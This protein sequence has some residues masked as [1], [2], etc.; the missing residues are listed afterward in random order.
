MR[1]SKTLNEIRNGEKFIEKQ[2]FIH[3]RAREKKGWE[4]R[5]LQ[6]TDQLCVTARLH[7]RLAPWQRERDKK[8]GRWMSAGLESRVRLEEKSRREGGAWERRRGRKK[9]RKEERGRATSGDKT[10]R[11][12]STTVSAELITSEL[13]YVT[14]S[15][16]EPELLF[17][18]SLS[19]PYIC[20]F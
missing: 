7:A 4:W 12:W 19:L 16:S 18:H 3:T 10:Q 14:T 20:S 11:M 2:N 9:R 6:D 17:F 5:G 8:K 15:D 1:A 13:Y